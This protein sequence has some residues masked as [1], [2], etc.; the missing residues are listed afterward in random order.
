MIKSIKTTSVQNRRKF[1]QTFKRE[2]VQN[3]LNSGKSAQVVG[4]ELGINSNLLYAW[5]KLVPAG[6]GG[7]APAAKPGSVADLQSQLEAA[8]RE[9]RHTREQ[10]T[11]L[12]KTLGIL[13]E[14]SSNDMNGSTR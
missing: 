14:P 12:K 10:V 8:H 4:E 2:A 5:R 11:I 13:S 9:L 3:W 1:D 7:R 6:T